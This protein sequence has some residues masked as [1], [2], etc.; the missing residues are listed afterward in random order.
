MFLED[1]EIFTLVDEL[2]EFE[3]KD[4][5]FYSWL[6]L[7]PTATEKDINRAYRKLSLALQ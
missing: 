2:E 6:N 7:E 1:H 3:G 5:N 4:V